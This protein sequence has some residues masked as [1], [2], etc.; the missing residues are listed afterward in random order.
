MRKSTFPENGHVGVP[1]FFVEKQKKYFYLELS[2]STRKLTM[3]TVTHHFG[4]GWRSKVYFPK[5]IFAKCTP[6]T[7]LLNF[8]SLLSDDAT[9]VE[10]L[11]YRYFEKL[12]NCYK[13]V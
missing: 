4:G 2:N 12:H 3:V 6:L 7:H 13:N 11:C 10:H 8:G 5:C 1:N 9:E